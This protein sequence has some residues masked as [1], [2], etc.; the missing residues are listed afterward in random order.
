MAYTKDDLKLHRAVKSRGVRAFFETKDGKY[1][2]IEDSASYS[3]WYK[4][5]DEYPGGEPM[6]GNKGYDYCFACDSG[7]ESAAKMLNKNLE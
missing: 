3:Y 7:A 2:T 6:Y 1:F 4:Y 5:N